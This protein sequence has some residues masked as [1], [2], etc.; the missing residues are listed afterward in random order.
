MKV[1]LRVFQE[2]KRACL[3]CGKQFNSKGPYNRICE[4]CSMMNERVLSG[5]KTMSPYD[6]TNSSECNTG[7][8]THSL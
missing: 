2:K 4:P 7:F 5:A 3:K 1:L 6:H 8:Y